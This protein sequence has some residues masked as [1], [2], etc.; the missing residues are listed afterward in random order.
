MI[1]ISHRGNIFGGKPNQENTTE[2]IDSAIYS[3]YDV[4]IDMHYINNYIWL[5]HD[6]PQYK[7]HVNYLEE[8]KSNLWIHCKNIPA[9]EFFYGTNFNYFWHEK[10][11]VTFTSLNYIWAYPGKQP[12]KN[13]IAVLPE[14]N[15]D[16]LS[17]AIGICSDYIGRY[18]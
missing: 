16:D 11:Q 13:S 3:G 7:I 1:L 4:E 18:R 14:L 12:I 8:R 5:G 2:Y 17:L 15:N 10:D 6:G 9:V